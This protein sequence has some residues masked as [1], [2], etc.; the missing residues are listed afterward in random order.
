VSALAAGA[1]EARR[2]EIRVALLARDRRFLKVTSFLLTRN[3]CGTATTQ[4]PRKLLALVE[5]NESTVVVVDA[6]DST[7]AVQVAGALQ[8]L[9]RE[10]GVVI[11]A[12]NLDGPGIRL[13]DPLPKWNAFDRLLARIR[14]AHSKSQ[15]GEHL[16]HVVF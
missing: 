5:R 11:V 12:D 16:P 3:G 13:L 10:V 7:H 4:S 8:A 1:G 6:T 9:G 14:S 2:P 15:A